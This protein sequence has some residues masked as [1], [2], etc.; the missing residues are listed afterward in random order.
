MTVPASETLRLRVQILGPLRV[1]RDGREVDVGPQQQRSVLA[2]LAAR[3]GNPVTVAEMIDPLWGEDPPPS[4]VNAVHRY[5]GALRRVLDPTIA[6][7]SPGRWLVRHG[8][9][10]RLG[11]A[12]ENLDLAAFRHAAGAA[13]SSV[14]DGDE[15]TALERYIEALRLWQG[16]P[17]RGIAD[18]VAAQA[19]FAS[20]TGEYVAVA[21]DAARLAR[22]LGCPERVVEPLR[23]AAIAAPFDEPLHAELVSAMAAAGRHADA[24]AAYGAIR[25][26]LATELDIEPSSVLEEAH[27]AVPVRNAAVPRPRPEHG[28]PAQLPPELPLFVGRTATMAAVRQLV[29]NPSRVKHAP[30]ILAFDGMPGIGKTALAIRVAHELAADYPDGQLYL[31]LHGFRANSRMVTVVEALRDLI[32]GLGVGP[33]DIPLSRQAMAGLYRT[34][35]HDRRVLVVLDDARDAEQLTDLLPSSRDCLAVVTSRRR[36][37]ALRTGAGADLVSVPLPDREEARTLLLEHLGGRPGV[38]A[39]VLDALIDECGRL[40]LALAVAGAHAAASADPLRAETLGEFRH[41]VSA[42]AREAFYG[43]YRWLSSA[44]ARLFRLLS[45]G[46]RSEVTVPEVAARAAMPEKEARV[47]LDE[48]HQVGLL[49]QRHPGRYCWHPLVRAFAAELHDIL[50]REA[51]P[52]KGLLH[53]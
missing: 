23:Q 18:T 16:R 49:Q 17:G 51:S 32:S 3:A 53:R 34:L 37:T 36:M 30:R 46:S 52:P 8:P 41:V 14:R 38:V 2:F 1:W 13:R 31:N 22:R 15:A 43:S 33:Q 28:S 19:L 25:D 27:R 21:V 12:R 40:P 10:Y 42:G 45:L 50:D 39:P 11:V 47:L 48:L 20:L 9:G 5:V 7:R 35:L 26:R 44:A 29:G 4:A 24:L 6:A